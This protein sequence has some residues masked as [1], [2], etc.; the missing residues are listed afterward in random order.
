MKCSVCFLKSHLILQHKKEKWHPDREGAMRI[1]L[2]RGAK[3][4][5]GRGQKGSLSAWEKAS[6]EHNSSL[7]ESGSYADGSKGPWKRAKNS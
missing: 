5:E 2:L 7:T 1:M 4:N 3:G 6:A